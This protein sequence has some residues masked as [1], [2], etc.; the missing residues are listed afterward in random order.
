MSDP[1]QE[2]N[3]DSLL[4]VLPSRG[5][6]RSDQGPKVPPRDAHLGSLPD[7]APGGAP[8]PL[9]PPGPLLGFG[10]TWGWEGPL[11]TLPAQGILR[12]VVPVLQKGG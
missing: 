11:E 12:D 10:G 6:L 1:R 7:V 5:T 2:G 3:A 8:G 4:Q 9:P